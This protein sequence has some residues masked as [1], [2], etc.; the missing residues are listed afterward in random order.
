MQLITLNDANNPNLFLRIV[1]KE[2]KP[3]IYPAF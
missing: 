2:E 1:K 3:S